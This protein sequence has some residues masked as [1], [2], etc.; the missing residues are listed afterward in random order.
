[1]QLN[2]SYAN[3]NEAALY[4]YMAGIIDGEGSIRFCKDPKLRCQR[5]SPWYYAQVTL[6]MT[7]KRIPELF[8]KVTGKGKVRMERVPNG[9]KPVY[10]WALTGRFQILDLLKKLLPY[11]I[12]KQQHAKEMIQVLETWN[13]PFN[14]AKGLS[15]MELQRREDTWQL[16]RKLNAVGARA[17]TKQ[18][19]NREIETIV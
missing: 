6:G 7:D 16:F 17:T 2:S 13:I 19:S 10:R 8:A 4:A 1:M 18:E 15:Q 12:V 3:L 11:L 9:R 5:I 14:R